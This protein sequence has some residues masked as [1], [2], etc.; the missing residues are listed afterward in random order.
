MMFRYAPSTQVTGRQHSIYIRP[1]RR[2]TVANAWMIVFRCENTTAPATNV[3]AGLSLFKASPGDQQVF[4]YRVPY[5]PAQAQPTPLR[6]DN[7]RDHRPKVQINTA[8]YEATGTLKCDPFTIPFWP[9]N[10]RPLRVIWIADVPA[11]CTLSVLAYDAT[12]GAALPVEDTGSRYRDFT[13]AFGQ[14][15]FYVVFSF[16]SDGA[17]QRTPTLYA[18]RAQ[19]NGRLVTSAPTEVDLL[20][21]E[22]GEG[23]LQ[24]A[25]GMVS[26]NAAEGE[27]HQESGTAT[28]WDLTDQVDILKTR[29]HLPFILETEYDP[30][31]TELRSVLLEGYS[32][33]PRRG[34]R[35]RG[36]HPARNVITD[37][38]P[39]E[40]TSILVGRPQVDGERM[41]IAP[42]EAPE[43]GET[44]APS[45]DYPGEQWS[46]IQ[47]QLVGMWKRLAEQFSNQ[48]FNWHWSDPEHPNGAPYKAT[49]AVRSMLA[50]CGFSS[51][52]IDVPDLPIRLFPTDNEMDLFI[53]PGAPILD[54]ILRVCRDYLGAAITYDPNA[55]DA[56]MLRLLVARRPPYTRLARFVKHPDAD[57]GEE[58]EVRLAHNMNAYGTFDDSGNDIPNIFVTSY[59]RQLVPPEANAVLVTGVALGDWTNYQRLT[60]WAVNPLS[61]DFHDGVSTADPDHPDYLGYIVPL[62]IIDPGLNTP[63]AVNWAVRRYYD[64]TCRAYNVDTVGGPLALVTDPDDDLQRVP[65]KLRWYDPVAV[66][67]ESDATWLVQSANVAYTSDMY[68]KAMYELRQPV[69]PYAD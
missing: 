60:Q 27:P 24:R 44:F 10:T 65:R 14:S 54:Y 47:L 53:E 3:G 55:G 67:W 36:Q 51:A 23:L 12:T 61:F 57:L 43:P 32:V 35:G 39:Y 48:R 30:E 22:D 1:A 7:R 66:G 52:Q 4:V 69:G 15:L 68:Q 42:E 64:Q 2:Q 28:V 9:T 17:Q 13:I 58:G 6:V 5:G 40:G 41:V 16:T 29:G 21:R 38:D 56:G 31:D 33:R 62:F 37:G 49:D 26:M 25:F 63:A 34:Q 50:W 45:H 11:G 46:E 18:Y 20:P 8:V 19:R 59:D